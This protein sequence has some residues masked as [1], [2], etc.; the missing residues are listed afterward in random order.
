MTEKK[1]T[2]GKVK[3]EPRLSMTLAVSGETIGTFIDAIAAFKKTGQQATGPDQLVIQTTD[4]GQVAFGT[5]K[6]ETKR[7][8]IRILTT[9]APCAEQGRF[10]CWVAGKPL[11]FT[12]ADMP[13]E[14]WKEL[15]EKLTTENARYDHI[16]PEV[17]PTT[18]TETPSK[19]VAPDIIVERFRIAGGFI[20][21]H[22]LN[23]RRPNG[24]ALFFPED[25]RNFYDLR[26]PLN[27]ATGLALFYFTNKERPGDWQEVE[28]KDLVD[29]IHCLTNRDAYR[30]G[31]HWPDIQ[32]EVFKLFA[33]TTAIA[34]RNIE[35]HGRLS[36]KTL[37]LYFGRI[38][39]EL[40]LEYIDTETGNRVRPEDPGLPKDSIV[41]IADIVKS[42]REGYTPDGRDIK[43]LS[44]ERW[45]LK[46]IRWRWAPS[47]VDDLQSLPLLNDTGKQKGLPLKD[48]HGK[49]LR[50]GYYIQVA[51]QIFGALQKLRAEKSYYA[52]DLLILIAADIYNL[53]QASGN[54]I[55]REAGR[56]F[57]LLGL[58][59][60]P[61]HK[62]RREDIVAKAI[63]RLKQSDIGALL[64]GSDET[65][66][67]SKNPDRRKGMFYSLKRSPLFT[68]PGILTKAEADA[69][70]AGQDDPSLPV[71]ALPSGAPAPE[72][73]SAP[74]LFD[75]L[76]T[77][78]P[79]PPPP[80]PIPTGA[81]IRAARTAAGLNIRYFAD[82][83][84]GPD[85][86]PD[87]STWSRYE[88][89][90]PIRVNAVADE[91]WD[92]VR[93]FI[94]KHGGLKDGSP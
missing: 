9:F 84:A 30:R 64:A 28:L 90:K 38:I 34:R 93:D 31:D 23:E 2:S 41:S 22:A 48:R 39:G 42:R 74:N 79:P 32:V 36:K 80:L 87:F 33:E 20:P 72:P 67:P 29:R 86:R 16:V 59:Y 43:A 15:S 3:V 65:P 94:A 19:V 82:A 89:G 13:L 63:F 46:A 73:E 91:T 11:A 85:K 60:D 14:D 8:T 76:G 40:G 50:S 12:V 77:D 70:E 81:E 10:R 62:N 1:T 78:G 24:G 47:L 92:R 56:L 61:K 66:R 45:K 18:T 83:M 37:S 52:H 51:E 44:G 71:P 6:T 54:V 75:I 26:T 69:L 57:D 55:E 35:K 4:R 25:R 5:F 58:D 53:R 88:T 17:T 49:P 68:P 7:V 21:H 27:W